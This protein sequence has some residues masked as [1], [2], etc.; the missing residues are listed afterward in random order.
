M[1]LSVDWRQHRLEL[2]SAGS[3]IQAPTSWLGGI[4]PSISEGV[5]TFL[6]AC[7][8]ANL[9]REWKVMYGEQFDVDSVNSYL[10]FARA[11][12]RNW[13]RAPDSSGDLALGPL[14]EASLVIR[15]AI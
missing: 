6:L 4:A 3:E 2:S 1:R 8:T 14:R 15:L 7:S 12:P 13:E 11:E 10:G 5:R 9:S